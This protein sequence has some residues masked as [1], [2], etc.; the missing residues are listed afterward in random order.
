ME[1]RNDRLQPQRGVVGQGGREN[2][3]CGGLYGLKEEIMLE[4]D[5]TC[6]KDGCVSNNISPVGE[7]LRDRVESSGNVEVCLMYV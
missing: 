4:V 3:T 5:E 1:A 6:V 7:D 2:V